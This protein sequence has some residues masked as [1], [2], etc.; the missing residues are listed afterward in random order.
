[1]R[2]GIV[3]A[4]VAGS[5]A[6]TLLARLGHD[7]ILFD[8]STEREKPCGGG[9]TSKALRR[10]KW[11]RE[12]AFP[13]AEVS[14]VRLVSRDGY[15]DELRL[16]HPV[17]VFSRLNLDMGLRQ[18]ATASGAKFR[19]EKVIKIT[20]DT[21]TWAI[22]TTSG[23]EEADYLI[24]ADGAR[25]IVRRTLLGR[26][27]SNDLC[28]ALGYSLH[29]LYDPGVLLINFQ[30]SGFQGYLWS[31]PCVDHSSV[32]IGR[33][34][35]AAHASDLRQRV[36][37]FIATNY[38]EVGSEGQYYAALIP[39]LSRNSLIQQKVCGKDWALLG[40]AAGFAD[41]ITAEGIYY[42]LRSAELLVEALREGDSLG[43]ERAWRSDF[44]VD[45]ESA[46]SARDRF[47]G[48]MVLAQTFIKR[49]LQ[50][51]RY[52]LTVQNLLDKLIAG[53][54]SYRSLFQNLVF[55]GPSIVLQCFRNR[56]KS[57]MRQLPG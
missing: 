37:A 8:H 51:V 12:S 46:A 31:F 15:A 50:T 47:Y 56:L 20:R 54:I 4:R 53:D 24:G 18:W 55:R 17:Q 35:P 3:G 33:W 36:E 49:A 52:S 10:I 57:S 44:G 11:L 9:V 28:L 27:S 48:G 45:L 25:S 26:Y 1:M 29:G 32:G 40:D 23:Q 41:A 14:L 19:P 30:E 38:P 34:L 13:H 7:V 2:I 6:A 42:A 43:Y 22:E 16:P 39:C 21:K 5:Y